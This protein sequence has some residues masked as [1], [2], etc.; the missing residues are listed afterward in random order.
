MLESL[1]SL[2]LKWEEEATRCGQQGRESDESWDDDGDKW[3]ERRAVYFEC[4]E[5]L[6]AALRERY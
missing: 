2:A 4:A 3:R 5:E 6:K 1:Q